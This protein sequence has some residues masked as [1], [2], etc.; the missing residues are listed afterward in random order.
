ML[1]YISEHSYNKGLLLLQSIAETNPNLH[2]GLP[3]STG[4]V[5]WGYIRLVLLEHL[6][7]LRL[8]ITMWYPSGIFYCGM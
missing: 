3:F 1:Y 7:E 6:K 5:D 2:F 8:C 4:T